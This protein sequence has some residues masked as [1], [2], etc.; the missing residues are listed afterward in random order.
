M[1]TDMKPQHTYEVKARRISGSRAEKLDE[2][3]E[4]IHE[5]LDLKRLECAADRPDVQFLAAPRRSHWLGMT[6][7]I[8]LMLV[9]LVL[10]LG[11][12][13]S[14]ASSASACQRPVAESGAGRSGALTP[15]RA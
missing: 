3:D 1:A 15:T 12:N 9:L 6:V 7:T 11:V 14:S 13:G 5:L 4:A 10:L 8:L 2:I